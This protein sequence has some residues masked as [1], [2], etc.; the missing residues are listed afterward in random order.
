MSRQTGWLII[1]SIFVLTAS[2]FAH[3]WVSH[4]WRPW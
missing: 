2:Q 4:G 1:G 3:L